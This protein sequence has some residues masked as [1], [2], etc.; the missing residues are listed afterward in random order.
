MD[1][2]SICTPLP[3]NWPQDVR[4]AVLHVIAL[5]HAAIVHARGLAVNSPDARTRRAGDLTGALEEVRHYVGPY[6]APVSRERYVRLL[7]ERF[8]VRFR[9]VRTAFDAR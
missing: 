1:Y 9:R 7:V 3:R 4:S 5:A 2:C 8:A 6:D